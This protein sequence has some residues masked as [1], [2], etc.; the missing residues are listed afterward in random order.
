MYLQPIL[1]QLQTIRCYSA[2]NF[3]EVRQFHEWNYNL[4]INILECFTLIC[5]VISIN[6]DLLCL[7][8]SD[9]IL[10]TYMLMRVAL[11]YA[12]ASVNIQ[13]LVLSWKSIL[14]LLLMLLIKFVLSLQSL[15]LRSDLHI[16]GSQQEHDFYRNRTYCKANDV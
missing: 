16:I 8:L 12:C 9:S 2:P 11:G 1:K 4:W 6:F 5:K 13:T 15:I 14:H 3:Q 10:A 7:L